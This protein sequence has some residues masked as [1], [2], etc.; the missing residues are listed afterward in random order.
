MS[1]HVYAIRMGNY[2]YPTVKHYRQA[3]HCNSNSIEEVRKSRR[4]GDRLKR[5]QREA[6]WIFKF[7]ATIFLCR[8]EEIDYSPFLFDLFLFFLFFSWGDMRL[9]RY[10]S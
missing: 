9:C 6:F 4:G 5:L 3:G 2:K 7:K 10:V 1:E 8:S